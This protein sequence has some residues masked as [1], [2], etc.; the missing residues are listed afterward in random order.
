MGVLKSKEQIMAED[1]YT[2]VTPGI[3]QGRNTSIAPRVLRQNKDF[4]FDFNTKSLG[5]LK[6]RILPIGIMII[7]AF[8]VYYIWKK[9][10]K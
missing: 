3:S 6:I 1:I 5:Q 9:Q 2:T 8:I 10:N 7:I 4:I